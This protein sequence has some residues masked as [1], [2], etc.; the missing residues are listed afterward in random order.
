MAQAVP[1]TRP[2]TADE[3]DRDYE[4]ETGTVLIELIG[5]RAD[6]L[7]A[8][9]VRGHAPFCWATTPAAAVTVAVT[10]EEVARLTLA[11]IRNPDSLLST[12]GNNFRTGVSTAIPV[13]GLA[14]T[15][16]RGSIIGAS[17]ESSNVDI[18]DEFTKLIIYQRAYSASARVITTT[19]TIA[20][21]NTTHHGRRTEPHS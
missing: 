4:G 21:T 17:L 14:N 19:I 11:S 10:L 20:I 15:G 13:I 8:A 9:L 3:V 2:L 1:L 16:G 7:P 6:E 5:E 18:A 12:G